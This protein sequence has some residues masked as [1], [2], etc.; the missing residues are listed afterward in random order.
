MQ[1]LSG[2]APIMRIAQ[3]FR[4][5]IV[6][7]AGNA[8]AHLTLQ[9]AGDPLI[10]PTDTHWSRIL[11]YDLYDAPADDDTTDSGR[12]AEEDQRSQASNFN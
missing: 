3:R 6:A 2:N 8:E 1:C 11:Y 7:A 10:P 5:N 4:M 12:H 9:P